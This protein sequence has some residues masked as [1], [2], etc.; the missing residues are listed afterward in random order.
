MKILVVDDSK[1]IY[2]MVE[3]MLTKASFDSLWAKDG[4]EAIEVLKEG[5]V[6]LILL[7]WNMPVMDG[8]T[9]LE[10]N[11]KHSFTTS[12]IVMMTTE[13]HPEKIKN[14]SL[15]RGTRIYYETF[16]QRYSSQ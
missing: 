15:L 14:G 2:R 12:P 10:E 5:E 11:Q 7:D 16:H 3:E 8:V 6:D 1:I 4:S 9:F 13:N